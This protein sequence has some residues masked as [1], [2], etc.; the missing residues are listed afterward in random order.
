VNGARG[1]RL[2]ECPPRGRQGTAE[3]EPER[4]AAERSREK[5]MGAALRILATRACSEGQLREKLIVKRGADPALVEDCIKR[6]KELGYV[7]DDLFAHSYATYRV[8]SKPLGRA[9]LARE[10]AVKKVSRN[11]IDE[12]LD[13]VFGEVPE[14][15]LI[16]RA[17]GRRI[18]THGK[19][20]DRAAAKRM[21]DHLSRLGFGYD[22]I[23]RKL[24]ALKA[25]IEESDE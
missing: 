12:A 14:E 13:L 23:S 8:K 18:R 7:N 15:S 21:F 17:I 6:L 3:V 20:A 2:E 19:P 5:V 22:L 25:E 4:H 10:L 16:D 24:R 9:R 11:R 1:R